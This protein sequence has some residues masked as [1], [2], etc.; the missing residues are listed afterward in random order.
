MLYAARYFLPEAPHLSK[1]IVLGGRLE[2]ITGAA[3]VKIE[4]ASSD[5]SLLLQATLAALTLNGKR[6]PKHFSSF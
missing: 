5:L 2:P 6:M 4:I 3:F 1:F